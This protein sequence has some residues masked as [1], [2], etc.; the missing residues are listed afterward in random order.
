[1]WVLPDAP[2]SKT[3]QHITRG[4]RLPAVCDPVGKDR[5]VAWLDSLQPRGSRGSMGPS[6]GGFMVVCSVGP[7][8]AVVSRACSHEARKHCDS[9]VQRRP[10]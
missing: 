2:A 6:L 4:Y 5:L 1:M 10:R 8:A 3:R 9:A 7:A